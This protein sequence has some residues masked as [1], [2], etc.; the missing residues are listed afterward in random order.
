LLQATW[1]VTDIEEKEQVRTPAPPF[2]TATLQMEAN[3]KLG[4]SASET[5]RTAQKLYENG[6]ITYMRTDSVNLS[7]EA[8]NAARN[9]IRDLYG[10]DYLS[11][12]PRRYTTRS[13]GAQEAHEAIRPAGQH[14]IPPDEQPLTG[15]EKALYELIWKRAIATQMAPARLRFQTVTLEVA[16]AT[17]RASG[18]RVEFPG[19]FRAYVEGSDDP[20]AA[21]E[22]QESPLPRLER[23]EEVDCREL[24]PQGHETKPPARYTEAALVKALEAE[25]IGRPSTYA[26]IIGTIVDRGYVI[27]QRK[28]LTPTFTAFAV[29]S[30][31][32]QHFPELVDVKFTAEMEQKLDDIAAGDAG[33]LDYLRQFYLGDKGLARQVSEKEASIDPRTVVAVELE[34][35]SAE[36]RIGQF[37]P[38]LVW[39]DGGQRVTASI[40][41]DLSPAELTPEIVERLRSQKLDGPTKLSDDP[42]T[43]KP[44]YLKVGPYGPYVQLGEDSQNGCKP[45]R[46]SLLKGMRME[47]VTLEVAL[48]LLSLPRVLGEHPKS[49]KVIKASV[50]RFGPY[51]VHDRKYV[52]VKEPLNVL[53]I[54]LEQAVALL[55]S[56]PERRGAAASKR[57]LKDLGLHPEDQKPVRVLDGRYGP[58]VNHGR[59]NATL[60]R[61]VS[62]EQVNLELALQLLEAKKQQKRVSRR[63]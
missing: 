63:R 3:R 6:F 34:D 14:M 57:A 62:P 47:D 49:G 32:E 37:G 41:L 56:A 11:E 20:E 35:R 42:E 60:P 48:K 28:E 23:G 39:N 26:S 43:G 29:T 7:E 46:A 30:L 36:V 38:F 18:R 16:D 31:L 9:R 53:D 5:M 21:L 2:T 33:W 51:V 25:G 54:S 58:Y 8:I 24:S 12:S 17:F 4:L 50:G 40:P 59:T 1:R 61:D 15:R 45:R 22:A 44:I 27:R 55:E 52:S 13:K 10:A 19:F